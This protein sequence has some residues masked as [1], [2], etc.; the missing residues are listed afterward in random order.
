M[1]QEVKAPVKTKILKSLMP[2]GVGKLAPTETE[3]KAKTSNLTRG[4]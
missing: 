4:L 1:Q 2:V 3:I